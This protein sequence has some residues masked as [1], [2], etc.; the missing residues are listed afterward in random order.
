[1][2]ATT[3]KPDIHDNYL[4][5]KRLKLTGLDPA[6]VDALIV[7]LNALPTVDEA[8]IGMKGTRPVLKIVYDASVR[9]EPLTEIEQTLARCGVQLAN[10]WWTRLKYRNYRVTDQNIYANARYE[11][12]CCSKAPPGK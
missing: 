12:S 10:D 7:Q 3:H 8:S 6:G 2:T 11:P 1:M 5:T 9:T 4:V